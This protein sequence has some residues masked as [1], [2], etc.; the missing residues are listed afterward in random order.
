MVSIT[1]R[2]WEINRE[3]EPLP[4]RSALLVLLVSERLPPG[5]TP[6]VHWAPKVDYLNFLVESGLLSVYLVAPTLDDS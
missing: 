4:V 1:P 3:L 2:V 6:Q 5:V